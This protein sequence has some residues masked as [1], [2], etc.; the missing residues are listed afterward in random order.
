MARR[1]RP[2]GKEKT[3][4][5]LW[6]DNKETLREA[7]YTKSIF[8]HNME[9]LKRTNNVRTPGAWKI[10]KHKVDFVSRDVIGFENAIQ[11]IKNQ[12]DGT[13]YKYFR[14]D[15]IGWK[16]KVNWDK[17]EYKDNKYYYTNEKGQQFTIFYA[18][19]K[20]SPYWVWAQ[21]V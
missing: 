12:G 19:D 17:V 8:E 11:G 6:E 3:I 5:Q 21:V 18:N 4:S 15:V 9:Q 14:K 16:N 7:G 1:G 2:K 13:D 20:D 10:F